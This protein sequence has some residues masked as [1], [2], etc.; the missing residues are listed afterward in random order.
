MF[1]CVHVQRRPL[2]TIIEVSCSWP[3]KALVAKEKAKF[4]FFSILSKPLTDTIGA[5]GDAL[6]CPF[7]CVYEVD[8]VMGVCAS[9]YILKSLLLN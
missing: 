4:I 2:Q 7:Y 1:T 6:P 8:E 9:E 3:S 5:L